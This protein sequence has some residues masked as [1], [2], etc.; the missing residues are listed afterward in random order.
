M[1]ARRVSIRFLVNP[2]SG[3]GKGERALSQLGEAAA[4]AGA[5]L[6]VSQN[7]ED[8]AANLKDAVKEMEVAAR[9]HPGVV[10]LAAFA[11]G[12]VVGH[13]LGRR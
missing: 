9:E 10:L 3:G 12:I 7:V 1:Q 2:A 6:V 13:V 4:K 11:S 8:L 5:E